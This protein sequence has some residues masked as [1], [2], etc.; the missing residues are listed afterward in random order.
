M[1]QG[2]DGNVSAKPYWVL[3]TP[4]QFRNTNASD[5]LNAL[6]LQIFIQLWC[7]APVSLLR[8]KITRWNIV[9]VLNWKMLEHKKCFQLLLLEF[10]DSIQITFRSQP[11]HTDTNIQHFKGFFIIW[12]KH[13]CRTHSKSLLYKPLKNLVE[14][15]S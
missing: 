13:Y 12:P 3:A 10:H 11:E 8:I 9:K 6:C 15:L 1:P 2:E 14:T 4:Y 7:G 5:I